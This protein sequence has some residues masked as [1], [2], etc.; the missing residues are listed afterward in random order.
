MRL[1]PVGSAPL[2]LKNENAASEVLTVDNSHELN[3][4][5]HV[6]PAEL[7]VRHRARIRA[8]AKHRCVLI[9]EHFGERGAVREVWM[10]NLFQFRMRNAKA[11]APNR[12]HTGDE[13]VLE[14]VT[15]GVSA[16][17]S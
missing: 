2:P 10:Q 15:K 12:R 1:R 5:V 11:P 8:K 6:Y 4:V 9:R 14:R 7:R 17:H 16:D 13:R 3:R